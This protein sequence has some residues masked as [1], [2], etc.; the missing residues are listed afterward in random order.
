MQKTETNVP[1]SFQVAE[2]AGRGLN[3]HCHTCE[4]SYFHWGKALLKCH[5]LLWVNKDSA[6][7]I[8]GPFKNDMT[9][10]YAFPPFFSVG[11]DAMLNSWLF[12]F[13]FHCFCATVNRGHFIVQSFFSSS[14]QLRGKIIPDT[15]FKPGCTSI[16]PG[17]EMARFWDRWV[18][19][20]S[21][22]T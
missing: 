20:T 6:K 2:T 15:A 22:N 21:Q 3:V 17:K 7:I 12:L 14:Q 4:G 16:V 9:F 19:S 11:K 1:Q 8:H 13:F 10:Q 5:Q 18:F